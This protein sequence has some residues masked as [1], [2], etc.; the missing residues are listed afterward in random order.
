MF[1]VRFFIIAS[2]LTV[3]PIQ[4]AQKRTFI[5]PQPPSKR[6]MTVRIDE[7]ALK[8]EANQKAALAASKIQKC[9]Q[10]PPS[11]LDILRTV[12]TGS[13]VQVDQFPWTKEIIN[14]TYTF[15]V[16]E[17]TSTQRTPLMTAVDLAIT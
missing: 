4:S 6:H 8:K 15:P 12:Q 11:A 7:V 16:N 5:G 3:L 2:L 14:T 13:L 17:H 9:A 1:A 10:T